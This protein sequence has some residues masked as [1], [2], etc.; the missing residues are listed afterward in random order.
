MDILN[1]ILAIA[2][3]YLVYICLKIFDALLESQK[4]FKPGCYCEDYRKRH[5]VIVISFLVTYSVATVAV[6]LNPIESGMWQIVAGMNL[7]AQIIGLNHL[8]VK[9]KLRHKYHKC[10]V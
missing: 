5:F 3:I 4:R 7:F 1:F 6:I 9:E 8:Y 10:K 2:C